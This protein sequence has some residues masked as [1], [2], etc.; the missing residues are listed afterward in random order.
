MQMVLNLGAAR[1]IEWMRSRLLQRLGK[2]VPGV[3]RLPIGQ[4]VK[5]LIGNRTRD[6]VSLAAYKRLLLTYKRWHDLGAAPAAELAHVIADVTFP[7]IK[8]PMLSRALRMIEASHPDFSLDFLAERPVD[9]ALNWLE[10]LPGITRR[11]SAS[12]LNFSTLNRPAF[13][14]DTHILRVLR[15]FGLVRSNADTRIA[16][17]AVM[18]AAFDWQAGELAELHVLLKRVG[19]TVCRVDQRCCALCPL[20]GECGT[21]RPSLRPTAGSDQLSLAIFGKN[22]VSTPRIGRNEAAS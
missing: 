12:V 10:R 20:S 18:A 14:V 9:Q 17:D 3:V 8:A 13:V 11:I 22:T 6:T 19:Q 5:S 21:A 2:P 16:Y 1:D 7:D 15:R 4:L